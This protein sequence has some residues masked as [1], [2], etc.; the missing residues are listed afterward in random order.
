MHSKKLGQV[1]KDGRNKNP[2][3]GLFSSIT[4]KIICTYEH[5]GAEKLRFP[6][7]GLNLRFRS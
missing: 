1:S 2:V 3:L 4:E 7:I 5:I 6:K